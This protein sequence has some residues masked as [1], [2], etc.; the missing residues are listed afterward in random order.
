V[1]KRLLQ[2]IRR[3]VEERRRRDDGYVLAAI[4]AGFP[5]TLVIRDYVKLQYDKHLSVH[6]VFSSVA[7][8]EKQGLIVGASVV[9]PHRY[10]GKVRLYRVTPA[11]RAVTSSVR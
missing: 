2:Y 1:I 6:A 11:G 5:R 3:K 10:D 7:R 9:A 4:D 8:L